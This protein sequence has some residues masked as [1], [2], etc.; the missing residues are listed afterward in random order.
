[1]EFILPILAGI[2]CKLYDD[3]NDNKLL[4]NE[5]FKECLKGS[6]WILLTL[7]SY[8]D[9]N[10]AV[11]NYI[12]NLL[13]AINNWNEW[14]HGY[15]TSLLI[16]CI[17]FIPI[18]FSSRKPASYMDIFYILWFIVCMSIEPLITTEEYSI[19][20]FLQRCIA[21]VYSV[22]GVVIGLYFNV[23]MSFIKIS[24]YAI[25]YTLISSIFQLYMLSQDNDRLL[26]TLVLHSKS[27]RNWNISIQNSG[28]RDTSN[29][30][31]IR[32]TYL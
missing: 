24:L 7:L 25:G 17:F 16:L 10:F 21:F 27:C 4:T 20:K 15:E 8:N 31:S 28:S 14:N 6:Q 32:T 30:I 11:S 9:F 12:I 19:K 1:M 29:T 13:N 22:S 3:L 5:V 26:Q 2:S 23:S 18:S